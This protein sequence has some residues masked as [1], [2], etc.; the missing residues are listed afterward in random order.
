MKDNEFHNRLINEKSPYLLQHANNPVD[1]YPWGDDA[2][3]KAD[4]EK[5]PIFLSIGYSTCHWCH[6]MAHESFEDPRVARLMN[7]LFIN[8][9]VDREER[10]DI[11]KIYM[12]VCQMM[13]GSGGWPL[14]IIMTPDKRPFFAATYIP[15]ENRSGRTGMLELLPRID[16]IWKSSRDEIDHT[17]DTIVTS[18]MSIAGDSKREEPAD[19]IL[20]SAYDHLVHIFDDNHGGFGIAPK[21]PSPQ[22]LL[23]LLR[24]WKRSGSEYAL[25]MVEKTLKEMH[26]GGIHDHIGFGFHRYSVDHKWFLPHFEKMLYDQAMLA[27]AYTEAYQATGNDLYA[28][29]ARRIFDYV[30]RHMTSPEGGFYSAEDADSEG[31]EGKF[32]VWTH[33]EIT[34]ILDKDKAELMINVF[35]MEQ[36]G[37]FSDEATGTKTGR[38]ILYRTKSLAQM[39]ADRGMPEDEFFEAIEQA[40]RKLYEAREKRIHPH[41]DDKILVDWNGL[42][43]AALAKGGRVFGNADYVNAAGKAAEFILHRMRRDD[44]RLLHRF[45]EDEAGISSHIDDYAFFIWGLIELYEVTFDVGHL[46]WAL[47][48]NADLI[49]NFWDCKDGGFFFTPADGENL[50][51]RQKEIYD[52]ALPS[53]NAI[54]MLN[55][56]RLGRMTTNTELLDMAWQTGS[57]FFGTVKQSPAAYA[58]LM[59]ALDFAFGPSYEVVIAGHPQA[60][61]TK[62]MLTTLNAHFIPNTVVI[63]RPIDEEPDEIAGIAPFTKDLTAIE[64]K[65]TAYVCIHNTCEL[66]TT[67]VKRMLEFFHITTD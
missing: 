18:L 51:I 4:K 65:A 41:K 7:T 44:G 54:A 26:C 55:M 10:P 32:Y 57:A 38:N 40:R 24:Y 29:T 31:E 64:G 60:E 16:E 3:E 13:T 9:K 11:D 30:L 17:A 23:F 49:D 62:E 36:S 8:I 6:V 53:G 21:F 46:K 27:I 56:L 33:D 19:D 52:G 45:R 34:K 42:M 48:L 47:D 39:A 43:I 14:T 25:E 66:P 67:N 59:V 15:K 22:N 20:K 50:I 2:F 12:T 58:Q 1:W 37:N 35:N 5:K 28:E 61:D 63:F